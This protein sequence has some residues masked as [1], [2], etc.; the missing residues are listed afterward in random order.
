MKNITLYS[1]PLSKQTF[2]RYNYKLH[3][4]SK[5]SQRIH[6]LPVKHLNKRESRSQ[7]IWLIN[8]QLICSKTNTTI[9]LFY[10]S[11]CRILNI[12]EWANGWKYERLS[13]RCFMSVSV[14][15]DFLAWLTSNVN[16]SSFRKHLVVS[17]EW[18]GRV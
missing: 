2:N 11:V 14:C 5:V 12:H 18:G 1:Q 9:F 7:A 4:I 10:H 16:I 6:I 17:G 15:K 3:F 13:I 8:F